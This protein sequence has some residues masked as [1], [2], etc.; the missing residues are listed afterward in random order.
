MYL[1]QNQN[2]WSTRIPVLILFLKSIIYTITRSSENV[3]IFYSRTE[4]YKYSFFSYTKLEWNKLE[5]NIQQS[6]TIMSFR[7]SLLQIS[8]TIPE[9]V[10]NIHN[11]AGLKLPL[12]GWD[13][14]LVI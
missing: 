13:S 7:N 10:Y 5:K 11:P 6:Q 2:N 1:L 12:L 3:T 8:L 4:V 9:P 14:D